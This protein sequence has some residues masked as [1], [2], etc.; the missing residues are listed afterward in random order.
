MPFVDIDKI[1]SELSSSVQTLFLW[2]L[3]DK[4][5]G[6]KLVVRGDGGL[7]VEVYGEEMSNPGEIGSDISKKLAISILQAQGFDVELKLAEKVHS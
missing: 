6:G 4:S 5:M 1:R 3:K 2:A 7:N